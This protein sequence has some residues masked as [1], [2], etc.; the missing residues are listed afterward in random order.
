MYF[1]GIYTVASI[2]VKVILILDNPM[3]INDVQVSIVFIILY[4]M[5]FSVILFIFGLQ[6]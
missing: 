6:F 1:S 5:K 3:I 4:L 2:L